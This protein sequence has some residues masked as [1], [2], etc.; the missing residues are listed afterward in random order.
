M[1]IDNK[2]KLAFCHI[3]RTGG[4]SICLA[5]DLEVIEKHEPASFYRKHFPS[6]HLFATYRPLEDRIKSAGAKVSE[7]TDDRS[8]FTTP[9]KYFLDVPVDTLLQFNN[10]GA[11]LNRMLK[12]L[13]YDPVTLPHEDHLKNPPE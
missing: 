5:L 13:G 4:V 10:L 1:P 6:Y 9:N 7:K 12:S 3:P 8:L 2:R 11:D